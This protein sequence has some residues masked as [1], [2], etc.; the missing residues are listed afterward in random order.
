MS[1]GVS[2]RLS[3]LGI[4]R[5]ILPGSAALPVRSI[6]VNTS[7]YEPQDTPQFLLDQGIRASMGA[8]AGAVQGVPSSAHSFSGPLYPTNGGWWLDNLFGDLSTVSN[9]A[10]GTAQ[11]LAAPV[12]AGAMTFTASG[13]LGAVTSGS[14][15]TFRCNSRSRCG[16]ASFRRHALRP[17]V[18]KRPRKRRHRK[19]AHRRHRP[20]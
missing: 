2:A 19:H 16:R 18:R 5:E 8:I 4:A 14:P 12:L 3:W 7:G 9:G 15:P 17:T 6:P 11:A 10:L 20:I 1:I 13:S